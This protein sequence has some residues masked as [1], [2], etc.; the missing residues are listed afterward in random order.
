VG[1]ALWVVVL[2][3]DPELEPEP[4]PEFEVELDDPE[5]PDMGEEEGK[6]PEADEGV[7][8]SEPLV[9]EEGEDSEDEPSSANWAIGGPGNV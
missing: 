6:A 7:L 1:E 9:E 2:E 5:V 3:A 8:G 4:E